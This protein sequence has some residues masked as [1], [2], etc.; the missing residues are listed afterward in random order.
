[1]AAV[2][3]IRLGPHQQVLGFACVMGRV[4]VYAP[5]AAIAVHRRRKVPLLMLITMTT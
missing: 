3:E 4:T 2:A 1:V 5:D